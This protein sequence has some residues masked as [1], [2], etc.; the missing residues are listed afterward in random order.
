MWSLAM[1]DAVCSYDLFMTLAIGILTL[2]VAFCPRRIF[3]TTKQ[4]KDVI[5]LLVPVFGFVFLF[6]AWFT[7]SACEVTNVKNAFEGGYQALLDPPVCIIKRSE[8]LQI[9]IDM[10]QRDGG[11]YFLVEGPQDVGRHI[12][13]VK[14]AGLGVQ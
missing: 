10:F 14:E 5:L 3:E 4:E 9:L 13:A 8:I 11:V 6:V 7:V 2:A 1:R 12:S